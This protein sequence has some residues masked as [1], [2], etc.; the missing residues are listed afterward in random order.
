MDRAVSFLV[1]PWAPAAALALLD[2]DPIP[3]FR[4]RIVVIVLAGI[5][6]V[7]LAAALALRAGRGWRG[8]SANATGTAVLAVG[9]VALYIQLILTFVARPL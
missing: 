2:A 3:V 4:D 9:T 7:L 6:A 8:A 5:A 1:L